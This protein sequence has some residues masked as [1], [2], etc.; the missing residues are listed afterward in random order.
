MTPAAHFRIAIRRRWLTRLIGGLLAIGSVAAA[1]PT[2]ADSVAEYRLKAAYLF[3]FATFTE[4]PDSIGNTLTL[5]IY[6]DDPFGADLDALTRQTLGNRRIAVRR[7]VSAENLAG[8]QLVFVTRPMIGNLSRVFD[9]LGTAP[10]L[11][12]ADSPGALQNGAMLNMDRVDGKVSFSANLA[13][14]RRQNLNL[15]AKLLRLATEVIQ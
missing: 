11:V 3:N 4:W 1:P 13:A 5:C 15:S 6:G 9:R 7:T 2:Q 12:V 14:A 8:C 10:T